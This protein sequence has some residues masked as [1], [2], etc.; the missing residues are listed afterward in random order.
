MT[1]QDSFKRRVRERMAST[2]ERYAAAHRQ[3]SRKR[4]RIEGAR[5]RLAAID[6]RPSDAK[7]RAATG[8]TWDA[9]FAL[10]D[11]DGARDRK[12]KENAAYLVQEHEVPGWWAQSITVWYERARGLR[13]KHQQADGFTISASKTIAVPV[14]AAFDAFVNARTR[15]KWLTDATMRLRTS[16]VDHT[17]RFDWEDGTTRV[18]VTFE[19]RAA[20]KTIVAI[21]H[22][23]LPDPDAAEVAKQAWRDRLITLKA[24]LEARTHTRSRVGRDL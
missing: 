3:V 15:R 21:A 4:Q 17:A 6:D 9:W 1:K 12:H 16:R 8:R 2:G 24:F 14:G 13:L 10:L 11:R 23:R 18:V 7:V 19:A 5:S 20:S 22:E